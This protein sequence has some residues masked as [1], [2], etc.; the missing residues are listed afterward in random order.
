MQN[1]YNFLPPSNYCQLCKT[2]FQDYLEH[3]HSQQHSQQIAASIANQFIQELAGQFKPGCRKTKRIGR[4]KADEKR[5]EK[6][7]KKSCKMS[8]SNINNIA[9]KRG[10]SDAKNSNHSTNLISSSGWIHFIYFSATIFLGCYLKWS[11]GWGFLLFGYP[12]TSKRSPTQM[13]LFPI[14]LEK[15]TSDLDPILSNHP[16]SPIH[17]FHFI[18]IKTATKK[19]KVASQCKC[20]RPPSIILLIIFYWG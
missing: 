16:Y 5:I 15:K 11:L 1:N 13:N 18:Q 17:A 10:V 3:T 2:S 19:W 14:F 12:C 9:A 8:G 20:M 6:P 4:K 7:P